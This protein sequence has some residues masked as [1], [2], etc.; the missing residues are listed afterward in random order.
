MINL[1]ARNNRLSVENE[2]MQ[3]RIHKYDELIVKY[4]EK[5]ISMSE[6]MKEL[7]LE[8]DKNMEVSI[9]EKMALEEKE[10]LLHK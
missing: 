1:Q 3:H 8:K 10:N 2:D 6:E 5:L 4:K 9:L 7:K